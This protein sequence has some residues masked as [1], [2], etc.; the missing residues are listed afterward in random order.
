MV[1]SAINRPVL[2]AMKTCII[3]PSLGIISEYMQMSLHYFVQQRASRP[4]RRGTSSSRIR[5]NHIVNGY[6]WY[7]ASFEYSLA[8]A[9]TSKRST[10]KIMILAL[11]LAKLAK[12][13]LKLTDASLFQKMTFNFKHSQN[14]IELFSSFMHEINT[15][16]IVFSLGRKAMA[17]VFSWSLERIMNKRT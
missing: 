15:R 3:I 1:G 5:T 17:V 11:P 10:V 8:I 7:L 14:P 12:V 13:D 6:T 9:R 16:P 4:Y 2:E